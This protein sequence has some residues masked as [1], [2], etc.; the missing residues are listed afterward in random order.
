MQ[1]APIDAMFLFKG[2][3]LY[4]TIERGAMTLARSFNISANNNNILV[5]AASIGYRHR[6]PAAEMLTWLLGGV[7]DLVPFL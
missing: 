2:N 6:P 1:N 5:L 7:I 4:S 3:R